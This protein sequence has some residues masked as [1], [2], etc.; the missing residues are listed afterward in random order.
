MGIIVLLVALALPAFNF[1]TGARSNDAAINQ[2][3]AALGVARQDA[4]ALQKPTGIMFFIEPTSDHIQ[5]ALVQET[6]RPTGTGNDPDA[7]AA[8]DEYLD[9]VPN[10][11]FVKL[12]IGVNIQTVTNGIGATTPPAERYLGFNG[13]P[14]DNALLSSSVHVYGVTSTP[15]PITN[16]A[17][18]TLIPLNTQVG[19]IILFDSNGALISRTYAL[20]TRTYVNGAATAT[21]TAMGSLL[22]Y[23]LDPTIAAASA[24]AVADYIPGGTLALAPQSQIGFVLFDAE[25]FTNA[26]YTP[27]DGTRLEGLAYSA[28]SVEYNEEAWLDQNATPIMLNR[29]NGTLVKGE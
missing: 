4:I 9:L 18:A 16:T 15:K 14:I 28:G 1:I 21:A 12:P 2:I 7:G 20:R 17:S 27:C 11:E 24:A 25:A 13:A 29:Y 23:N 6:D 5:L 8:I 3:S 26:G 10:A 19:G 22:Y